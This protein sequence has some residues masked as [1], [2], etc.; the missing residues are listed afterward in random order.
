MNVRTELDKYVEKIEK[1][2]KVDCISAF[3]TGSRLYGTDTPKSDYD[4]RG[5]FISS[6]KQYLGFLDTINILG[7]NNEDDDLDFEFMEITKFLTLCLNNNPNIVEYLFIPDNRML[8]Q[9]YEWKQILENKEYFLS[10]KAKHTFT[11]Y[12]ISQ[13]KR[14]KRHRSWLLTPPKKKPERKDYN[15][16][17]THK[18]IT[19]DQ[20]G[21]Y[22]QLVCNYLRQV[23]KF[24]HLRTELEEMEETI[25]YM[26]VLTQVD[27]LDTT[28]VCEIYPTDINF[29]V[30][31][32]K[33]KNYNQAMKEFKAYHSW[34]KQRNPRRKVLETNFGFDTKHMMHCFRLLSEGKELLET[35]HITFPRPDREFLKEIRNGV[36]KYDELIEKVEDI[37]QQFNQFY[38]DSNLPKQPNVNKINRVCIDILSKYIMENK[39]DY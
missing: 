23:G 7:Q 15:L 32:E 22:N 11:G 17:E 20:I 26:S 38:I 36:Y 19:S 13:I 16:P 34:K 29:M 4:I 18:L 25:D 1:E 5:V 14:L 3:V 2:Q 21:A 10:K 6:K 8:F 37:E 27:K 28:A 39:N 9:S 30:A 31:L 12:A 35:G 24:H 33:E